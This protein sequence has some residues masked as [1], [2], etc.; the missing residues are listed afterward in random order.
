M[1]IYLQKTVKTVLFDSRTVAQANVFS[2]GERS[3][4]I[5]AISSGANYSAVFDLNMQQYSYV[6]T[7]KVFIAIVCIF[8][9][10]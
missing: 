4:K 10:I 7:Y 9:Q 8:L 3:F 6:D 2:L 1:E 5:L